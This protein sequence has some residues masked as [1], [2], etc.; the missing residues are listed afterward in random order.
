[1]TRP[2]EVLERARPELP[3]VLVGALCGV[4][5][6]YLG[7]GLTF[8]NDEWRWIAFDGGLIDYFR[9]HNEHW[10]TI[11]LLI[12]RGT[13]HFV[14]LHSYLPYLAAVVAMHLAAVSGA[15]VLMRRRLPPLPSTLLALPLALLGVGGENL[16]WAFQT[17]FVGSVAFGLWALVVVERSSRYASLATSALLL[18]SLM[19]SGMGLVMV[20]AVFMRTILDPGIRSR[21]ASVV[22]PLVALVAWFTLVGHEVDPTYRPEPA[23]PL[24]AAV[25]TVRGAGRITQA[26]IGLDLVPAGLAVGVA[27]FVALCVVGLMSHRRGPARP[28]ALASLVSLLSLYAL[29]GVTRAG[30]GADYT[31]KSRYMYV[32]AFLLVIAV[33]DLVPRSILRLPRE[34]RAMVLAGVVGLVFVTGLVGNVERVFK[35]R[36]DF[37]QTSDVTRA[38]VSLAVAHEGE[39]WIDPNARFAL[40]LPPRE[41]T[42]TVA[43]HEFPLD[44]E[45]VPTLRSAPNIEAR[46]FAVLLLVGDRFHVEPPVP[47]TVPL[48]LRASGTSGTSVRQDSEGC[49]RVRSSGPTGAA[50]VDARVRG[51]TRI[52]AWSSSGDVV[53]LRLSRGTPPYRGLEV[54][55]Q[56]RDARDVVI[57]DLQGPWDLSVA[58]KGLSGRLTLCAMRTLRTGA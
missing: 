11:P 46:D 3:F 33:A 29:L 21:A 36:D 52:R 15:Y 51:G 5:L 53:F 42:Q 17:G 18:C 19:C 28:L 24:D 8:Y 13:F 31:D 1:M 50:K 26:M 27:C 30:L 41:L 44:G 9:P 58:A 43:R 45:F 37:E 20:I 47:A 4:V 57:P 14:E 39:P 16:F 49:L 48:E 35:A 6:L 32:A 34:R 40:T 23:G 22:V 2:S 56:S 25:F 55:L 38:F 54:A 7:R 12:Y 10:S